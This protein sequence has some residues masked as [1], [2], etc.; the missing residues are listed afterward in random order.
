MVELT[1]AIAFENFSARFNREFGI[2][3]FRKPAVHQPAFRTGL[4]GNHH[5]FNTAGC[6][7]IP[8]KMAIHEKVF[9]P[10]LGRRAES[11]A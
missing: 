1:A 7:R 6:G 9:Y 4:V 3:T 2:E 5:R 8:Q 11:V 10:D